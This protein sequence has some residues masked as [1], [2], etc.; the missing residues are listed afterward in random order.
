MSQTYIGLV[1]S[2][3]GTFLPKVGVV[4]PNEELTTTVSALVTVI[5]ALWAFWGRW[6]KGDLTVVGTRK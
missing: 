6:R 5:G 2:L 3:L 4:L 1:V